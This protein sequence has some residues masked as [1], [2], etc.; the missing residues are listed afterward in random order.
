MNRDKLE[1]RRQTFKGKGFTQEEH[2]RRREEAS[3][4]IRRVKRDETLSKRR[5][6]QNGVSIADSSASAIYSSYSEDYDSDEEKTLFSATSAKSPKVF[7]YLF[8]LIV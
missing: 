6:L 5:G 3:V 4:E 1:Q 2:R 7:I 8:I